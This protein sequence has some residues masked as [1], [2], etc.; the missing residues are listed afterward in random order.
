MKKNTVQEQL[1]NEN[2]KNI[3]GTNGLYQIS[4]LGRYRRKRKCGTWYYSIGGSDGHGYLKLDICINGKMISHPK[5]HDLVIS[6]FE[7]PLEEGEVVH[8]RSE[9]KTQNNLDNLQLMTEEEHQ[10]YHIQK[11]MRQ[12]G[13]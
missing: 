9:I 10:Q 6:T 11:R 1:A 2:F 7:R 3:E 12:K 5:M 8:H 4:D 13:M